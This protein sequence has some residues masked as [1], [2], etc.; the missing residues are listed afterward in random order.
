MKAICFLMK[1]LIDTHILLWLL[2]DPAKIKIHHLR[3]LEDKSKQVF[4][5][6]ISIAEISIKTKMGK[7]KLPND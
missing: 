1:I 3:L 5:S 7:L 4:F 6:S 2:Y